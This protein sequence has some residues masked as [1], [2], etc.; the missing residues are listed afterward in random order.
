MRKR[1]LLDSLFELANISL[2][3]L[4]LICIGFETWANADGDA[5]FLF[6]WIAGIYFI[7][8]ASVYVYTS[9]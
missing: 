5:F 8:A 6:A 2:A 1:T 3:L 4:F 7:I 9:E